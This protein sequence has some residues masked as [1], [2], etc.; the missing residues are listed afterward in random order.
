MPKKKLVSHWG[1]STLS[2]CLDGVRAEWGDGVR[3]PDAVRL[4]D[5]TIVGLTNDDYSFA[6]LDFHDAHPESRATYTPMTED[7][8]VKVRFRAGGSSPGGRSGERWSKREYFVLKDSVFLYGGRCRDCGAP[9]GY[10]EN[11]E[12]DG[13]CA[14]CHEIIEYQKWAGEKQTREFAEDDAP[15]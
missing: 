8:S 3:F 4:P 11:P 5:G 10:S 15:F 14:T 13:L 1:W 7:G 6:G 9:I 2:D 12:S